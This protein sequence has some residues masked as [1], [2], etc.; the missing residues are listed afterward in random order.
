MTQPI[1]GEYDCK[2]KVFCSY[3]F[4]TILNLELLIYRIAMP[5]NHTWQCH[6]YAVLTAQSQNF[7]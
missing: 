7:V 1:K 5:I 3:A 2:F 4:N 6:D